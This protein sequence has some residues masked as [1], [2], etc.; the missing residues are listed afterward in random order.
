MS[1]WGGST[2]QRL[3][4]A[5][6]ADVMRG[7]ERDGGDPNS[8]SSMTTLVLS[9]LKRKIRGRCG[10][11]PGWGWGVTGRADGMNR[12]DQPVALVQVGGGQTR[13]AREKGKHPLIT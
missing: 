2:T 12:R 6:H 10:G 9:E 1:V 11:G 7:I 13:P 8:L 4:R 5:V 3:D